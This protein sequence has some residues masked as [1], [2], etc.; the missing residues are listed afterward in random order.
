MLAVANDYE[1]LAS[2]LEALHRSKVAIKAE[3]GARQAFRSDARSAENSP[4]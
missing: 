2:S 3:L 4:F 1:K